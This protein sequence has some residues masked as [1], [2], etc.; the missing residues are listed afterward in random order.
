MNPSPTHPVTPPP[1]EASADVPPALLA[2]FEC[3]QPK[4]RIADVIL[5]ESVR[6]NLVLLKSRIRN[7]ALIYQDWGFQAVAPEG[8]NLAVSFYGPS[9]T[10]KTMCAEA[11]AAE[12][13]KPI[14]D[15][16]Y[17]EIESKLVGET[18]KNIVAVFKQAKKTEAVL[19]FDEADSI[20]GKRLTNVTQGAE[21]SINRSRSEM[22]K[23]MQGFD[24]VVVFATNLQGNYDTAFVRRILFHIEVPLPD[25]GCRLRLWQRMVTPSVPGRAALDFGE[26]AS[27]SEG[28]SG[29][30]IKNA[31]LLA[32]SEAANRSGEEKKIR[33]ADLV[34]AIEQVRR[35]HRE[36]GVQKP[37]TTTT[38]TELN[39][40]PAEFRKNSV[41]DSLPA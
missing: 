4:Y 17:A 21:D 32:L 5:S 6:L 38:W 18:T 29:G 23:Q 39:E 37:T 14:I 13:G 25:L 28:L 30:L 7:H 2:N 22:L 15:V 19:F 27:K 12:L 33:S 9:G 3:R 36:V 11:L 10:G 20:L 31:T 40:L 16:S 8:L 41:S 34:S 26:L 35:A 24:G 1:V